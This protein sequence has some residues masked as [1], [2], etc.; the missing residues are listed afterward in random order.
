MNDIK[1]SPKDILNILNE[2]LKAKMIVISEMEK[3]DEKYRKLAEEEK[4]R[5]W[6]T[7]L[8]LDAQIKLYGPLMTSEDNSAECPVILDENVVV[9]SSEATVEDTF[10]GKESP[11]IR[12]II[13]DIYDDEKL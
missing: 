12:P 1:K 11:I 9:A 10:V 13:E 5:L 7:L 6:E 8:N 3:V 2:T 4:K